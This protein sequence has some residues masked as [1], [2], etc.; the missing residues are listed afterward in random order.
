MY[1]GHV[2]SLVDT[3]KKLY[4]GTEPHP[5]ICLESVSLKEDKKVES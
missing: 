2:S 5:V 4:P 3:A 1:S